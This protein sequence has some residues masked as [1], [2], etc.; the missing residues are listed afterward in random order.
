MMLFRERIESKWSE[1]GATSGRRICA[2]EFQIKAI[3]E[4]TTNILIFAEISSLV[5]YWQW[6]HARKQNF[7]KG[8]SLN[9]KLKF[10]VW[11]MT[12]FS[13]VASKAVP[14]RVLQTGIWG[15][16]GDICDFFD[17]R[18]IL[19]PFARVQSHLKKL[20]LKKSKANYKN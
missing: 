10:F 9:P 11:K 2:L 19:M 16:G 7:P 12:Y 4:V 6:D 14:L 1:L 3:I 18:A 13:S 8:G 17:K 15:D 5:A 20:N